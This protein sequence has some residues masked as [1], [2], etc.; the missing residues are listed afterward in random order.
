MPIFQTKFT[1]DGL[2]ETLRRTR[3]RF[4]HCLLPQHNAGFCEALAVKTSLGQSEDA[5][6]NVPLL[7]SQIRGG[8]ILDAVR[9][10]KQGFPNFLPLGEFRRR[11]RLLAGD[12]K[13]SSPVLDERKAVEDMLL[14]VDLEL[15]SYRVGLSQVR[16]NQFK[17]TR[18]P[19]KSV[20]DFT[21]GCLPRSNSP[22]G[23]ST[24]TAHPHPKECVDFDFHPR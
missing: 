17:K 21:T 11:F 1:V 5:L 22:T 9:L 6:M 18:N 20:L 12:N 7:R 4:V 13:I 15:S 8:Q 19:V 2:V 14:A 16:T 10:H 24:F 23:D 3:L